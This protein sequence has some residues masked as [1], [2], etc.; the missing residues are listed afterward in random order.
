[1]STG[2]TLGRSLVVPQSNE[3]VR[4]RGDPDTFERAS[5]TEWALGL[6]ARCEALVSDVDV[7]EPH[8]QAAI[9]RL[10][11]TRIR[12]ELA[13]AHLLYGEWLRRQNRRNDARE[14]LRT[15]HTMFT[16]MGMNGFADRAAEELG[17]TGETVRRR[18]DES[19]G[20][21]T[22]QE[23]QIVRLVREGL[24]NQEIAVHLFISRR[25]VEW[26]LSKIFAKLEI[27]SR[28]QLHR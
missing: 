12:G 21:L 1:M 14:P 3:G 24:S 22:A 11:R 20:Q 7:A 16:A 23:T 15:A 10:S 17:A 8:F 26:H 18:S 6:Q 13:R 2:P 5:G 28:R 19:A 4:G 9:D 27:T 25:T